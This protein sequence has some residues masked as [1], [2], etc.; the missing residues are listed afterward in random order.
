MAIHNLLPFITLSALF[1]STCGF[2]TGGGRAIASSPARVAFSRQPTRVYA[3]TKEGGEDPETVGE[4][5]LPDESTSDIL[6]SP[7]FLRR[8]V[9]VLESDIAN[10]QANIDEANAA[11]ETGKAEWGPKLDGLQKE[12]LNVQDRM[13]RQSR[14][15]EATAT[16]EVARKMLDV[17]DNYDRAFGQISAET[18]DQKVIAAEYLSTKDMI[19]SVFGEIGI[20]EVPTLGIE[21]DYEIHQAVLQRPSE[22]EEGIVCEELAKGFVL[23]GKL[24]RAAMVSVSAGEY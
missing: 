23:D 20:T 16:I 10:V 1:A 19:L 9:E 21:F 15:G 2:T 11:L 24:I 5:L 6:N 22:F 7:D 12:Y 4:P 13:S 14:D 17:L 8:K 3:D 18:E